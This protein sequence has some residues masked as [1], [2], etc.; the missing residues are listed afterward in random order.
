MSAS[1]LRDSGCRLILGIAVFGAA[2]NSAPAGDVA[3]KEKPTVTYAKD[4]A[5]I[6]Q[7]R[8]QTC[9][10]P[11]TAAP[12]SLLTYEQAKHWSEPI[13]E[14]VADKRMPPWFADPKHGKFSNDRRLSDE[15]CEKILAW[16]DA[17]CVL[18]DKKD[19]PE[20]KT[21]A[22]GW[23]IGKPDVVFE[24]PAEQTIKADGVLPYRYVVTPTNFKE[25]VWIEAAEARPGN[26]A[27]VHHIIVW[28]RDPKSPRKRDGL[29]DGF[30]VGMARATCRRFILRAS[31]ARYLPARSWSGNCTTRRW[32]SREGPLPGRLR[33]LQGQGAAPAHRLHRGHCQYAAQDSAGRLPMRN[34]NPS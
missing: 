17:G 26:R 34:S 14:A 22:D 10:H 24:L 5:R 4:V 33:V 2:V 21:F 29:G 32:Q 19:L 20:P 15:Q 6:M 7:D 11:G 18:G 1:H 31:P 30:I 9:H 13:R 23:V 8:C 27:V 25:D 28:Y 16:I 12:F 3:R